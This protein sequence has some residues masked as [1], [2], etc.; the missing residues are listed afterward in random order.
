[1]H[2]PAA[3]TFSFSYGT[4]S[5]SLGGGTAAWNA[6][7]ERFEIAKS[8]KVPA[9][10]SGRV[11]A[12]WICTYNGLVIPGLLPWT[13][14]PPPTPTPTPIPDWTMTWLGHPGKVGGQVGL[15]I[16][17]SRAGADCQ[18]DF[19]WPAGSQGGG[20]AYQGTITTIVDLYWDVPLFVTAGDLTF[21]GTCTDYAA[22]R[23]HGLS[24]T[25]PIASP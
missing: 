24:G 1:M 20:T 8:W 14:E 18:V 16:N 7:N 11:V 5:L 2:A 13:I 3:C 9:S 10:A 6:G 23:T 15:T 4:S 17:L 21:T 22:H 19:K 12:S 25:I